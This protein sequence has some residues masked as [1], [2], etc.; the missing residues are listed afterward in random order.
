M[1]AL[2]TLA[3]IVPATRTAGSRSEF[4]MAGEHGKAIALIGIFG[5]IAFGTG[6]LL[7]RKMAHF[8]LLVLPAFG[9]LYPIAFISIVVVYSAVVSRRIFWMHLLFIVGSGLCLECLLLWLMMRFI[10]DSPRVMA[11]VVFSQLALVYGV[12]LV[13]YFSIT[14]RIPPKKL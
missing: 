9:H 6:I 7:S 2:D 11:L 3:L 12:S 4:G 1:W 8:G 5:V 13:L 14:A 10:F